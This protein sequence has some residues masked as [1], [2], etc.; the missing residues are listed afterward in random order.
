MSAL[1]KTVLVVEDDPDTVTYLKTLLED[2]GYNVLVASDAG[3]ALAE[4]KAGQP[5]LVTLDI[6]LATT[7]SEASGVKFYRWMKQD[8]G[9]AGIPIVIVTGM[10]E[11][12]EHFISTRRQVP[13]P[14]GYISKPIRQD[15]L[16]ATVSRLLS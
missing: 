16:L 8:A 6:N 13:A 9:L 1:K 7:H 11:Q 12:F 4:V 10:S 14:E 5:D 2:N 3:A 15:T